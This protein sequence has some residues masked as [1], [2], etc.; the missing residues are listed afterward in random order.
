MSNRLKG[1]LIIFFISLA[2]SVFGLSAIGNLLNSNIGL[3]WLFKIRGPL[4]PPPNM[5]VV[6]INGRTPE[7][8]GLPR[9]P[10]DWPRTIHADLMKALVERGAAAV[11]FDIHFFQPKNAQHD[12]VFAEAIRQSDRVVLFEKLN[13]KR[14]PITDQT[15][16]NIGW[17]WV[18]STVPPMES[19]ASVARG[20][21]PF[22]LPKIDAE[23]HQFWVFK[24]SA[25]DAPTL[26]SVALQ[27]YSLPV[28]D[29][30]RALLVEADKKRFSKLP[31]SSADI[32]DA[33]QLRSLMVQL[34]RALSQN[35]ELKKTLH[36]KLKKRASGGNSISTLSR[37]KPL[38]DMYVGEEYR[39]IN[40]YGPPGTIKN[41]PYSA[42]I[43]GSDP[44]LT[45]SDLDF[46]DK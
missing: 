31:K 10:R 45:E 28:Y 13:G 6:G 5:V 23:L 32:R 30:F 21:G 27:L 14:Q 4:E 29:K 25:A 9:L 34:R 26:P 41:I 8:L 44:N 43:K 3:S 12:S 37:L 40:L 1:I 35:P 33:E 42:V 11:V 38:I 17:V 22:P 2:G 24:S 20:L 7:R 18:E 15:G 39:Y 16:K 36:R 19:L 46:T